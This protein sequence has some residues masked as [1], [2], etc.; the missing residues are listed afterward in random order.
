MGSFLLF[1]LIVFL[2]IMLFYVLWKHDFDIIKLL[3]SIFKLAG[4]NRF[5][6]ILTLILSVIIFLGVVGS[7]V[8]LSYLLFIDHWDVG[9]GSVV[10][11]SLLMAILQISILLSIEFVISSDGGGEI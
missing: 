8:Y 1:N 2:I 3:E 9:E 11:S 10:A 4:Y 7:L 6:L 5:T